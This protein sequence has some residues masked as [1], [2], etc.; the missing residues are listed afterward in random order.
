[1]I[2][3]LKFLWNGIKLDGKLYRARYS[4]GELINQPAGTITIYAKDC[5]RFPKIEGLNV[6]NDSDTITDY[7]ERDKIRVTPD[8]PYYKQVKAALDAE[9]RHYN[10]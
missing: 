6:I 7:H 5:G 9:N 1:M 8:N 2:K 4:P 10:R 3:M